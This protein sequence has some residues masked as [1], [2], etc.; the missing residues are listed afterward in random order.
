MKKHLSLLVASF[1]ICSFSQPLVAK[2]TLFSNYD[3]S[4]DNNIHKKLSKNDL[5]GKDTLSKKRQ[6]NEVSS[7]DKKAS[8]NSAKVVDLTKNFEAYSNKKTVN[9]I[10]PAV[11]PSLVLGMST[12]NW[13]DLNVSSILNITNPVNL[14]L[15]NIE[16]FSQINNT[17]NFAS[18]QFAIGVFVDGELRLMKKFIVDNKTNYCSS[19]EFNLEG[20]LENIPTGKHEVKVYAFNLPK[21]T[22]DFTTITYGGN[23]TNC[24]KGVHQ[25]SKIN[26]SIQVSE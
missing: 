5:L 8:E 26:L 3:F 24:S 12:A 11:A 7:I 17:K 25:K 2:N 6:R 20:V 15:I 21:Q 9:N 1:L 23:A 4:I 10:F 13:Q 18:Y 16:G 22:N 19:K 14:N